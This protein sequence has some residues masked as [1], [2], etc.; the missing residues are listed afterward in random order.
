MKRSDRIWDGAMIG[1]KNK[2]SLSE[3]GNSWLKFPFK[4]KKEFKIR[5]HQR[6]SCRLIG[7]LKIQKNSTY[8][9]GMITNISE[10]GLRFRPAKSFILDRRD[11]HV[12]CIFGN[13]RLAG[14]V[15]ASDTRGYGILLQKEIAISDIE[16]ILSLQ[17]ENN[18]TQYKSAI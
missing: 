17:E 4:K 2:N 10:S 11:T 16:D 14:K 12:I 3:K 9:E 7:T 13:L 5:R 15:V 1:K 6:R 8:L 18:L